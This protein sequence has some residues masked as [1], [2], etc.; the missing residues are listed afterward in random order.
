MS[1][2]ACWWLCNPCPSAGTWVS[3]P[4]LCPLLG[5]VAYVPVLSR[6]RTETG[7]EHDTRWMLLLSNVFAKTKDELGTVAH[8][9]SSVVVHRSL[10]V[11]S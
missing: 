10:L 1:V 2:V 8:T 7:L 6:T 5:T 3:E 9:Y 11:Q 4:A